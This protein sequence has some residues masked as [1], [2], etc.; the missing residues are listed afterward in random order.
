MSHGIPPD[1]TGL[2]LPPFLSFSSHLLPCL[3]VLEKPET[4]GAWDDVTQAQSWQMLLLV[5]VQSSSSP[6]ALR[7]PFCHLLPLRYRFPQI[8]LVLIRNIRVAP[9]ETIIIPC[10]WVMILV[11]S[12]QETCHWLLK[13]KPN[14]QQK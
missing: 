9:A 7:G 14:K 3:H 10:S 12:Q 5:A 6:S 8:P 11:P 4:G 13:S 1:D 2:D